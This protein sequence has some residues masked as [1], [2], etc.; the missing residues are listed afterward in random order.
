MADGERDAV[1]GDIVKN[2]ILKFFEKSDPDGRGT[3]SEERFRA[4]VRCHRILDIC[5]RPREFI[6]LFFMLNTHA[7]MLYIHVY[8]CT[9]PLVTN[10]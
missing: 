10:F 3:V 9:K 1:A 6:V 5:R 8:T 7:N 4:F 2:A